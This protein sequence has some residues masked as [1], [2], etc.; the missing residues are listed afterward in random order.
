MGMVHLHLS[1]EMVCP[2]LALGITGDGLSASCFVWEWSVHLL[3]HLSLEMVCP[4]LISQH[5]SHR[6]WSVY[7]LFLVLNKLLIRN[8]LSA[9]CFSTSFSLGMVCPLL[10]FLNK[11]LIRNGLSASCSLLV[12]MEW[13]VRFLFHLS[14]EMVCPLLVME[15]SVRFLFHLSL[16]MVC[17]L[18]VSF[19]S[20]WRWSV[21]FLFASCSQQASH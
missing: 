6:E 21:R 18:L 7:F 16:E 11:L 8:G 10:V 4:L 17:P 3:F 9:S 14:L 2:L 19:I 1:L 12:F 5:A 20:H 13:S 15:W